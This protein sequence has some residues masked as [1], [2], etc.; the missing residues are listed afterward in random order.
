MPSP[1]PTTPR[2]PITLL[3][4]TAPGSA[5]DTYARELAKVIEPE[6]KPP[7]AVVERV[8]G[9][10]LVQ[11]SAITSAPADGYTLGVNTVSHLTILRTTA[12]QTFQLSDFAWIS[13]VQRET[14]FTVVRG[15]SPWKTL[16][17]FVEATRKAQPLLNVGG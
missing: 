7:V 10:G 6:L 14:F 17:E 12:R 3:C 16:G 4:H 5:A 1:R 15:D 13:R 8:G 2:K 9:N 11:M